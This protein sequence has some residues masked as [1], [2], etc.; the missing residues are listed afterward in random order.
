MSTKLKS[1]EKHWPKGLYRCPNPENGYRYRIPIRNQNGYYPFKTLGLISISEA[2]NIAKELNS[3]YQKEQRRES[4]KSSNANALAR[5]QSLQYQAGVKTLIELFE[6]E[7]I[8]QYKKK[9]SKDSKLMVGNKIK[10][11]FE[12]KESLIDLD[13]GDWRACVE[14][15]TKSTHTYP[16]YKV[17][18]NQLYRWA[19]ANAHLPAS[20][21]NFGFIMNISNL[22]KVVEKKRDKM[23]IEQF[24]LLYVASE[25]SMR[26]ILKVGLLTGLRLGDIRKLKLQQVR[27]GYLHVK[28]EKTG[29]LA[30]PR[31]IRFKI[32]EDLAECGV[33]ED[34]KYRSN[35]RV[36][37]KLVQIDC[38]FIFNWIYEK[39][40]LGVEK[41]HIN[42]VL[43]RYFAAQY[44]KTIKQIDDPV[45]AQY[46][47]G[48]S[49]K[50]HPTFHEIRA[51]HAEICRGVMDLPEQEIT[52]R[53]G[54]EDKTENKVTKRYLRNNWYQVDEFP[55]FEYLMNLTSEE[56]IEE[57]FF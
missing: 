37:T 25:E 7:E 42:Q 27:N 13:V 41:E 12:N 21:P 3:Q 15:A 23:T 57:D 31:K 43:S 11:F 50:T 22:N 52:K 34:L 19:L 20:H 56:F 10:N 48:E 18:I 39:D 26:D 2:K 36:P 40:N 4:K 8:S 5:K 35:P 24:Q 49:E 14:W 53:L 30:Y 1:R 6:E 38:P 9:S 16:K 17:F 46:F 51:L 33:G 28:P 32:T 44:N 54:Q 55:T 47:N 45:W 29:D